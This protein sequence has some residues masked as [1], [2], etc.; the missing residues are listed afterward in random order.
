M[1]ILNSC[2]VWQESIL[3]TG[4]C[5]SQSSNRTFSVLDCSYSTRHLRSLV[6]QL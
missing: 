4:V 5:V 1:R 6:L 2:V 3:Q